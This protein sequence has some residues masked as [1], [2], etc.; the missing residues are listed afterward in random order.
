[1][2]TLIG[3]PARQLAIERTWDGASIH[4]SEHAFVHVAHDGEGLSVYVE[5]PFHGDPP[6]EHPVGST[7]RLW[8]HE[9]V[10]LFVA[11]PG[12][13]YLEIELGPHG[14]H[15]ALWLEGVRRPTR[16]G[17]AVRYAVSRQ[18]QRWAG[19]AQ[20]DPSTPLPARPWRLNAYAI[21]GLGDA[22]RHLACAPVPGER[23]DFHRP[24]RFLAWDALPSG[25]ISPHHPSCVIVD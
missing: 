12:D 24:E 15:L 5:A 23:P 21:H 14:H 18:A 6:P 25:S 1:M 17:L 19:W 20:L 4:P 16:V 8:E 3:Q 10:E 7:P 2:T 9:V 13:A 11:G 22:R